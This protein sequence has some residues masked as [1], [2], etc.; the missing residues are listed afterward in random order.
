M[1]NS[2]ML[3]KLRWAGHTGADL[4]PGDPVCEWAYHEIT[5]L[6]REYEKLLARDTSNLKLL[7]AAQAER[8]R[9]QAFKDYVHQRLDAASIPKN[10]PGPHA[11][12]GC[13]VGQRLDIALR[14]PETK[15][16]PVELTDEQASELQ[17]RTG[18][19]RQRPRRFELVDHPERPFID[20]D[21]FHWDALLRVAGDFESTAE[22]LRYMRA[23]AEVLSDN[24][25]RI[26][27][28]PALET[29]GER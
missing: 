24:E 13:R 14:A 23:I 19:M 9:L 17:E 28:R 7:I 15:R 18:K 21:D 5:R 12:A 20:D 6:T 4:S 26:P 1:N 8:D 11:D 2:S 3:E 29:S 27:Y 10:P 25:D 22:K 16:E